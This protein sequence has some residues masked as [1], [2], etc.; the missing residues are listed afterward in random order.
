[1]LTIANANAYT[2]PVGG[3]KDGV[4]QAKDVFLQ[5]NELPLLG[6]VRIGNFYE[7]F[8]LE[9]TTSD[10]FTTFMERA[11][12]DMISPDR[13]IGVMAFDHLNCNENTLWELGASARAAA[14]AA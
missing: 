2:S 4:V 6:H 3:T 8:G 14:T 1:M 10:I 9:A 11:N 12:T 13:H 5:I 7:P